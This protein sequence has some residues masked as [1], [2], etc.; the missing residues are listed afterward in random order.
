MSV[1]VAGGGLAGA[2]VAIV[3]ARAGVAVT[4]LERERGPK[5][6]VCGEFLSTTA[7]AEL[8]R[9]GV[10]PGRLGAVPL[11]AFTLSA[12]RLTADVP[13]P[14]P[15]VS[16]SRERLDAHLLAVAEEAGA[17]VRRGITVRAVTGL[18]VET[19]AGREEG[20]VVV[21][22]GKRDVR[23][24]G[25][26]DG[27]Q[28]GYVGLKRYAT[29]TSAGSAALGGSVAVALLPG[30]YAGVQ[31]IEDGRVN[32]CLAIRAER[33]RREGVE[34]LFATLPAASAHLDAI[35]AGARWELPTV[36]VGRVPYGFVRATTSGAYYVG[37]QAAVIPSLCGEGMGIALRT[38][39]LAAE[40]IVAGE[41]ASVY[42]RRQA[43]DTGP[44]VR[45]ATLLARALC[46]PT[47]GRIAAPF[48]ALL[49]AAA[50]RVALAARL[51]ADPS[52]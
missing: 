35:L 21:A 6:A 23:G 37:D 49:P 44:V 43:A 33:V 24:H 41:A 15:A 17:S 10:D 16:L 51:P 31:A 9:L 11:S 36:A 4:V 46:S 18:G 26:G 38:A 50:G 1:I 39:R 20:T 45:R 47:L 5:P 42:Q 2:A 14:F 12:G 52:P 27:S 13:L 28:P 3:L 25:R 48:A 30:G 22:T 40:A 34:A 29:L 8:A 32:V 19:S 7:L